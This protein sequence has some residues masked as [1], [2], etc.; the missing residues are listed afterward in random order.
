MIVNVDYRL[1][2]N[3]PHPTPLTDAWTALKWV[4]ANAEEFNIDVSRVSVG[5]LSAGA[6]LAAVVAI[7]A[8]DEPAMPKLVC[9][10]LTVPVIDVRFVPVEGSAESNVPYKSYFENEF[11]PCLPLRRL[12]WFYR[13]WLGENIGI[14]QR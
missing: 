13:L 9:Q 5:G 2:P 3:F 8:R 6:N 7:L 12:C 4:F 11:A 1:A 10:M 14:P